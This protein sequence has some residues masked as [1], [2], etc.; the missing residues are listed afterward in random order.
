MYLAQLKA[1][2]EAG[3]T[4]IFNQP[5][6]PVRKSVLVILKYII[7]EENASNTDLSFYLCDIYLGLYKYTYFFTYL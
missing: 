6:E 5:K 1:E 2:K 7:V 4:N 3:L